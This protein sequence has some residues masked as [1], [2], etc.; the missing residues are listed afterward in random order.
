VFKEFLNVADEEKF[1]ILR[2]KLFQTFTTCSLYPAVAAAKSRVD[3]CCPLVNREQQCAEN[4]TK[5][6]R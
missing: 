1:A 2:G 4:Y 5:C 3:R 6:H